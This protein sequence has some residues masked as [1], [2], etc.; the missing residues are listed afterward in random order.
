MPGPNA[1]GFASQWN[2]GFRRYNN[3]IGPKPIE[4]NI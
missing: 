2:I 1:N 4:N 3:Y